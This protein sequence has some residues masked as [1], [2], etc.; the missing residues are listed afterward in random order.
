MTSLALTDRQRTE[1]NIAILDY[2][3]AQGDKFLQTIEHFKSEAS[4]SG[5]STELG[6]GIL[7]KKWTSVIRLQ[8]RVMELESK[9]EQLQQQKSL[10]GMKLP[11][12]GGNSTSSEGML[13]SPDPSKLL[14]R[15]PARSCLTGHRAA[16]TV[17][18]AHPVYSLIA[19]GSEDTTIRIWDAE[20]GQYERTLKGHTGPITNLAFDTKGLLLASCSNDMSAKIW[21]MNSYTCTRTLKGHDHTISAISFYSNNDQLITCSRD[22][23][24]KFW[25]VSTGYCIKTLIGNHSDWIKTFSISLDNNYLASSGNDQMILIWQISTGN[26]LQVRTVLRSATEFGFFFLSIFRHYEATNMWWKQYV[27]EKSQLMC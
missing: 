1:L 19:S 25:E 21:D 17:V 14:P 4:L 5:D 10:N 13:S 15:P 18:I 7:E 24:I 16:V 8:K 11:S 27:L 9:V 12:G 26:V 6:K 22:T 23:T 20:T 3:T 2:L